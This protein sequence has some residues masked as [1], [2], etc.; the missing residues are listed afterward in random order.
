MYLKARYESLED[1]KKDIY[2]CDSI[3]EFYDKLITILSLICQNG[4]NYCF[5]KKYDR[6]PNLICPP[7]YIRM[8]F[9][10]FQEQLKLNGTDPIF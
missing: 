9:Y 3:E 4:K 8:Y 6:P 2:K 5:C 10:K 1:F 7:C